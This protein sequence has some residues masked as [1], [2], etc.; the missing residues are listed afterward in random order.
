MM[1]NS[2]KP[3]LSLSLAAALAFGLTACSKNEEPASPPTPSNTASTTAPSPTASSSPSITPSP[4]AS[5]TQSNTADTAAN[6]LKEAQEAFPELKVSEGQDKEQ[7]QLALLSAK[8]Y[9]KTVYNS[10]YLTNGS[11]IKNGGTSQELVKLYGKDWSDSYRLK[12]ESLVEEF[13]NGSDQAAQD[14]AASH[15]ILNMLY[16]TNT[17][18]MTLP[19]NCNANNVGVGSCLV[20]GSLEQDGEMTY[21]A[22]PK[23]G[24]VYVNVN[25]TANVRFIKDGVQGVSPFKYKIQLEMIK[26]PYPDAENLRYAYIVNDIG[27]DWK[28]ETWHKGEL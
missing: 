13:H 21:Q 16:F 12:M 1:K 24:K 19:D 25:F 23:T 27:G 28:I 8:R 7:I 6:E 3:L 26:N 14:E 18:D 2:L 4:S 22:D 20:N 10:G 5:S 15:L 9:V 17:S 11:W